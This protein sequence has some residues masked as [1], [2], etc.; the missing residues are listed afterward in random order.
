[1][2]IS[3]TDQHTP[4]NNITTDGVTSIDTFNTWRK[5]TNGII[6]VINDGL[7]ERYIRDAAIT[8]QKLSSGGPSWDTNGTFH[9][10]GAQTRIGY[11]KSGAVA[12]YIGYER[13][14][15]GASQLFF[16]TSGIT[17]GRSTDTASII[18][19]GGISGNLIVYNKNGSLDLNVDSGNI[20]RFNINNT[21]SASIS[22]VGLNVANNITSK[23]IVLKDTPLPFYSLKSN[24][25]TSALE[26]ALETNSSRLYIRSGASIIPIS[27]TF[28]DSTN[29]VNLTAHQFQNGDL[30]TFAE[31]VSDQ[32]P[33]S[34]V[35]VTIN[36]PYYIINRTTNDF[37]ISSS[38][39]GTPI[40][41]ISNGT[42][43]LSTSVVDSPLQILNT[44]NVVIG[45]QLN[46]TVANNESLIVTGTS[47]FTQA[48]RANQ[49]IVAGYQIGTS[50]A[51]INIGESRTQ[52]GKSILNLYSNGSAGNIPSASITREG[53]TSGKLVIKNT[54]TGIVTFETD[55]GTSDTASHYEFKINNFP[56]LQINKSG[57][58]TIPGKIQID[59]GFEN[60]VITSSDSSNRLINAYGDG[61]N[62]SIVSASQIGA[63]V[64][65]T[66]N[67]YDSHDLSIGSQ[68]TVAGL[69]IANTITG[70]LTP[71]T[72]ANGS[73]VIKSLSGTNT[74]VYDVPTTSNPDTNT[75]TFNTRDASFTTGDQSYF[76][77]GTSVMEDYYLIVGGK[78][79]ADDITNIVLRS[80]NGDWLPPQ[81]DSGAYNTDG[82][83][84]YKESGLNGHAGIQNSGNAG[85][86][87]TLE[88]LSS[89]NI[90]LKTN[91]TDRLTINGSTG[92]VGIGKVPD[93]GRALDVDGDVYATT[94]FGSFSG[95][96]AGKANT[97]GTADTSI[98]LETPNIKIAERTL[99]TNN[100]IR[101]AYAKKD[102]TASTT[103]L[104]TVFY[105]GATNE[106]ARIDGSTT[107]LVVSGNVNIAAS[108]SLII[109]RI[110]A[111][112]RSA[113]IQTGSWY[114]GQSS[115]KNQTDN[116][117]IHN[118]S[119]ATATPVLSIN[120]STGLI[121]G[122]ISN[123][124][125]ADALSSILAV[126][127]GGTGA[128]T[129]AV[130]R[131]NL[132][133][134]SLDSPNFTGT[135][136]ISSVD[137]AT[138]EYVNSAITSNNGVIDPPKKDGTYATG[139]WGI[140]ITGW[141][142]NAKDVKIDS[143]AASAIA[144]GLVYALPGE[145]GDYRRLREDPTGLSYVPKTNT[146]T[147]SKFI[148]QLNGNVTGIASGNIK[149]G[150]GT[151]QTS[152]N[153]FVGWSAASKLRVQVDSTDFGDNW[154]IDIRGNSASVTNGVYTTGAQTINGI[155][156]FTSSIVGDISGN[157]NTV[158]NGVYIHTPQEI[159]GPKQF[160]S[161]KDANISGSSSNDL[162]S[163]VCFNESGNGAATMTF[164][165]KGK[166]GCHFGLDT[167][168]KLKVGGWSMGNVA[169]EILH[170]G[171][172]TNFNSNR[173]EGITSS[174]L[175]TRNN[176]INPGPIS[177]GFGNTVR[178][179]RL[180]YQA[181][182][183]TR[184]DFYSTQIYN[185]KRGLITVFSGATGDQYNVGNI[186]INNNRPTIY[187]NDT[188]DRGTILRSSDNIF[189]VLRS[190]GGGST[191][192]DDFRPFYINLTNGDATF[193]ADIRAAGDII[194]YS[195]SDSRLKDNIQPITDSLHKVRQ[196]SGVTFTWNDKQDA[197]AGD[198][199]GV[200]AQEVEVV[201]PEATTTRDDGYK[202]VK[203]EKLIP[204]LI[205]SIKELTHKVET[206]ENKLSK[207]EAK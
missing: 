178:N 120:S 76:K 12:T 100:T 55:A 170:A 177:S 50:D 18:R 87:F 129:P 10:N 86:K 191:E 115:N 47:L 46:A 27:I 94:F 151:N 145:S 167:D 149:Q 143:I 13:P 66:I 3:D 142:Q 102:G 139:T 8:P 205:E 57:K 156:T 41:F 204:L 184:D 40:N 70:A 62:I 199:V 200:I 182:D 162:S 119:A 97:A 48:L 4:F 136:K 190:D 158:T 107:S 77:L 43:K 125:T 169:H 99:Y 116:F 140:N 146:L 128:I 83:R 78:R 32:G 122:K 19:T 36:T 165:R 161:R 30:I 180:S 195:S 135:P 133:A 16:R 59:G 134:A 138:K 95:A 14:S 206:L 20:I 147:A 194:A 11:A 192:F 117:Y 150:G 84:I 35:G 144:H 67:S 118:G 109:P 166:F 9:T 82:L 25:G 175:S 188:D 124:V 155:K 17:A 1:M 58:V 183:G 60:T 75:I 44:N 207:L 90:I 38:I 37:Q 201:L 92:A 74:F 172:C 121:T 108:K 153:I 54:G 79:Q 186:E 159:S 98:V 127:K 81:T 106:I 181:A 126:D 110:S 152:N 173:A 132:G 34:S 39:G 114:F 137:I 65:V 93:A 2:P 51:V 185:G 202:A 24:D 103:P 33:S 198:D 45:G 112:D 72:E 171:N 104:D 23:N 193:G 49:A 89:G 113:V 179:L 130:A 196:L 15:D 64:T 28:V 53:G 148:G 187:L 168:N 111:A 52:N 131:T 63:T 164:W 80:H 26:W 29:R 61:Y 189:Y 154:P 91:S 174:E 123:A 73:F 141:A 197:H 105:D 163:L 69:K 88:N 22:S 6:K 7:I 160:L 71:S 5:K 101:I 157:A 21:T 96:V 176:E 31:V 68:I 56:V 42:G 85:T 203:Y